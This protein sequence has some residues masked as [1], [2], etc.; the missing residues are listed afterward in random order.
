MGII[1][2]II[3]HR[4]HI[5]RPALTAHGSS[6]TCLRVASPMSMPEGWT[7]GRCIHSAQAAPAPRSR[8][9]R[10]NKLCSVYLC[11][12]CRAGGG[13]FDSGASLSRGPEE[14]LRLLSRR[15]LPPV[16]GRRGDWRGDCILEQL[17]SKARQPPSA[18]LGGR[19]IGGRPRSPSSVLTSSRQRGR[20][21]LAGAAGTWADTEAGPQK[22]LESQAHSPSYYLGCRY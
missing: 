21:V 14:W 1:D 9:V 8:R 13:F 19:P 3:Y 2:D 12:L 4:G 11:S 5:H 6:L 16:P 10:Q 20:L 18:W 7:A 17:L 22:G 15:P